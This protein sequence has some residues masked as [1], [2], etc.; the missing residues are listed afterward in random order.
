MREELGDD[1]RHMLGAWNSRGLNL[2]LRAA[3]HVL[4]H[5]RFRGLLYWRLSQRL[6]SPVAAWLSLRALRACGAELHPRAVI[7][8]GLNLAHTTG[9]VVGHEV[10][11]GRDLVL[12]Q[13]VTLGHGREGAGQPRLGDGVRIF[14]GAMVLGPIVVGDGA[15]I[16]AGAIVLA[17]VPPGAHVVGVW[18]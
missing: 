5:G 1:L 10:Q 14:A 17:D 3:P 15:V 11:A 4:F 2:A 18:K 12:Y 9:I 16:G 8:P 6:P 7:G 13:G